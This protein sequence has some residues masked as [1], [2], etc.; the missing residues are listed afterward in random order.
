M[1]VTGALSNINKMAYFCVRAQCMLLFLVLAGNSTRFRIL[2]SYT[3][4]L[5]S[6][7]L[8]HSCLPTSYIAE[9]K[10][11][12]LS[13]LFPSH[14]NTL[15]P[16]VLHQNCFWTQMLPQWSQQS[17]SNVSNTRRHMKQKCRETERAERYR[18]SG[19]RS[20][21][22]KRRE[23]HRNKRDEDK[24]N[25]KTSNIHSWV[26]EGGREVKGVWESI[27][28]TH[29]YVFSVIIIPLTTFSIS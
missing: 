23:E 4:L 28:Y 15:P 29:W 16:Y 6:P 26:W 12:A 13:S 19:H 2:R 11:V 9:S 22:R 1:L 25:H 21:R 27:A 8:M 5:K 10:M 7:V 17:S 24:S 18:S 14:T 3:L 20:V